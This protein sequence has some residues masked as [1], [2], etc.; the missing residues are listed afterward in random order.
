MRARLCF[1]MLRLAQGNRRET[2]VA[3]GECGS[4]EHEHG[5]RVGRGA[6]A[7]EKRPFDTERSKKS[8][9]WDGDEQ[10]NS[11][12]NILVTS[13]PNTTLCLG[14]RASYA[15]CFVNMELCLWRLMVFAVETTVRRCVV[16]LEHTSTALPRFSHC[17]AL[18]YEASVLVLFCVCTRPSHVRFQTYVALV[19][20]TSCAQCVSPG[21]L[22]CGS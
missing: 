12:W 11:A 14:M 2:T 20:C 9:I 6:K 13:T 1:G 4:C 3:I 19:E 16:I 18:L 21:E 7:G 22:P 8:I 5:S 10:E 17:V 15:F